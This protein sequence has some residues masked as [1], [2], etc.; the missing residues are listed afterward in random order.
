MCRKHF[1]IPA[2]FTPL[3]VVCTRSQRQTDD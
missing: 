3:L 1:L 2:R